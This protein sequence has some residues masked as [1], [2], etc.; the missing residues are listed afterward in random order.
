MD[1]DYFGY[2]VVTEPDSEVEI[3]RVDEPHS[4]V[5]LRLVPREVKDLAVLL[6]CAV[7]AVSLTVSESIVRW[8]DELRISAHIFQITFDFHRSVKRQQFLD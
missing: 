5:K 8:Q 4:V 2:G 6:P 3:R 1:L 7:L